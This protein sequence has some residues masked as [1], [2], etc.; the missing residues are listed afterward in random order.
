[1]FFRKKNEA[2]VRLLISAQKDLI[3]LFRLFDIKLEVCLKC[4][5]Q[6]KKKKMMQKK[7]WVF[8]Y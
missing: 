2:D 5:F 3:Y 6:H 8:F 7:P 1:M 4:F